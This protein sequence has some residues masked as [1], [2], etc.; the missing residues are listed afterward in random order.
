[1]RAGLV[2]LL[3]LA[4]CFPAGYWRAPA[5]GDALQVERLPNPRRV[6]VERVEGFPRYATIAT[7]GRSTYAVEGRGFY[8]QTAPCRVENGRAEY[9]LAEE[10]LFE[11]G[12]RCPITAV[13]P[14]SVDDYARGR[15]G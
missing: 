14:V 2:T 10:L 5:S 1:M 8:V 9:T 4:G 7:P 6:L 11:D 12:T 13:Y 3:L 15:D